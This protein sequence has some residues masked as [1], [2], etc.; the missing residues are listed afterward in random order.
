M[1]YYTQGDPA[2]A[3][4]IRTAFEKLGYDTSR[5]FFNAESVLYF[6]LNGEIRATTCNC[7]PTI[8]KTHPDYKELEL[9]VEPKFKVGDWIAYNENKSSITP[10]QIIRITEDKYIVS[11]H[12]SYDFRTLEADWH[13]WTI[14]DAKDG[15][16]LVSGID[17]PFIYNGNIE[18]S[19]AGAYVGVSR[20]G[21]IR[22]DVFPS[23]AWTSIKDVKPATK[24]QRDLL[25]YKMKEVGCEWDE[26]KKE[27]RKIQPHYDIANFKA[28]MPVLERSGNDEHWDYNI[29]SRYLTNNCSH[30][31]ILVGCHSRQCIP[32]NEETKHLLGTTDPCDEQYIN[33]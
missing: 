22:L 13:L 20:N 23:K 8:I 24:E 16:V 31:F 17:N 29:F 9:A 14:Q 18:F 21:R 30:P 25:F 3:N 12:W 1:N 4:K 11:G 15:D 6:T 2:N 10:M 32:F 33:W 5:H 26:K 27:L 19:S 28:G 7:T